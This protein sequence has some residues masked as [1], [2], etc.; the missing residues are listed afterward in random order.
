MTVVQRYVAFSTDPAG[1]NLAGVVLDAAG[2]DDATMLKMAA[3]VGYSETAFVTRTLGEDHYGVR[4]FSPLAE[5]PFCG[6]ATIAT[7]VALGPGSYIF[8]TRAGEVPVTVEDGQAT[9][10]SVAPTIDELP[11]STL[12][13][14]LT[15][16]RWSLSDLDPELPPQIAYAGAYHPIIAARSRARLADLDY[17]FDALKSLMEA[18]GWTTIQ[19]VHRTGPTTFDVRDPFPVGG[20]VED[21]ATGAAAAALGGYL[22]A[23]RLV[24]PDATL[25][26][27]QGDDLGR[28]SRLTVKLEPGDPGVRV[29]GAAVPLV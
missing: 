21:P 6:H 17:N 12:A 27:R 10:T 19:L 1:G 2:L 11:P 8:T 28:P 23:L 22:R 20:V 18:R 25:H 16:L 13:A 24:S 15:A 3:D 5:V 7:A 14:L 26:L 29:S 4:Y 9:L